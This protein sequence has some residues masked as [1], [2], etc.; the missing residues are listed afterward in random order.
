MTMKMPDW[1]YGDTIFGQKL[2]DPDMTVGDWWIFCSLLIVI[3]S[4]VFIFLGSL[5]MSGEGKNIVRL[6]SLMILAAPLGPLVI[7]V[8]LVIASCL[9]LASLFY[10]IRKA[11]T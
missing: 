3:F 9:T 1:W 5:D 4:V 11:W 2:L 7:A 6:A 8:L 10:I